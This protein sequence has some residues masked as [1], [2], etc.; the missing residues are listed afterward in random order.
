MQA[1]FGKCDD[2]FLV[3]G[4]FCAAT[5]NR[6]A[7][8]I[9]PAPPPPGQA[10]VD[11][12][13]G[14]PYTCAQ[15]VRLPALLCLCRFACQ[16]QAAAALPGLDSSW[17]QSLWTSLAALDWPGACPTCTADQGAGACRRC[18]ASARLTS[19]WLA[20]SA[21]PAASRALAKFRHLLRPAR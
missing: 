2:A 8:Y 14:G 1:F 18:L 9:Y 12:E 13:P 20:A 19:S 11:L 17:L 7:G 16:L 6:C 4:Q 10:C 5:C 15:Q 3:Q 21:K